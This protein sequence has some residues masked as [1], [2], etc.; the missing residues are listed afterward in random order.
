M[1]FTVI[2]IFI[3]LNNLLYASKKREK[4]VKIGVVD[5]Q[6]VWDASAGRKIAEEELDKQVKK[7]EVQKTKKEEEIKK[8]QAEYENKKLTMS[9]NDKVKAELEIKKRT[10]ELK[11]FIESSRKKM[12]EEENILK[13]PLLDDIKAVVRAVSIL[14][15]YDIILKST[16]IMFIDKEF[17]ITNEIIDQLKVKYKK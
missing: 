2:I 9:D 10:I 14:N 3:L 16:S 1:F 7:L 17:D 5:I 6:E 8:L 12:E 4:L 15:G 11:E 13:A